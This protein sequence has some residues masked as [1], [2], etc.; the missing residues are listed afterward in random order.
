[1]NEGHD[2]HPLLRYP[3]DDLF[4]VVGVWRRAT[5][6]VPS[7]ANSKAPASGC[8]RSLDSSSGGPEPKRLKPSASIQTPV[9]IATP[10][11]ASQPV[12]AKHRLPSESESSSTTN[13]RASSTTLKSA[14]PVAAARLPAAG[15]ET[16]NDA[17]SVSGKDR[18]LGDS[19]S[20]QTPT[21]RIGISMSEL[22]TRVLGA[23]PP[24]VV[25]A[26][27]NSNQPVS[28]E[29]RLLGE[30]EPSQTPTQRAATIMQKTATP[31][32]EARPSAADKEASNNQ[33]GSSA[34]L[35]PPVPQQTHVQE[36]VQVHQPEITTPADHNM[37]SDA[38][39]LQDQL[40]DQLNPGSQTVGQ[41]PVL[42]QEATPPQ[43]A[44]PIAIV[45]QSVV[46]KIVR[47]ALN[48][49]SYD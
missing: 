11:S 16:M 20:S 12:P 1:M 46:D 35:S 27:T 40:Q 7:T 18:L 21:T 13:K 34:V 5:I 38:T 26:A 15:K 9:R 3:Y 25:N 29:D 22:A 2:Q 33:H 14:T 45:P 42:H 6:P 8:R 36:P 41:P 30:S 39:L 28:A 37:D 44:T 32:L 10:L 24:P 19:T 17:P 31:V 47:V 49:V 4:E 48:K 23:R 43:P